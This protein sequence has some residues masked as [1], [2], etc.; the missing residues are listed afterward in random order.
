[1][2]TY[3]IIKL[4]M[5]KLQYICTALMLLSVVSCKSEVE[6][7][8]ETYCERMLKSIQEHDV[9]GMVKLSDEMTEWQRN[10]SDEERKEVVEVKAKYDDRIREALF[11]INN[12]Q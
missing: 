6:K 3:L 12:E 2:H 5:K 4:L 8:A 10:L 7:Q 1:M 11:S 9:Q